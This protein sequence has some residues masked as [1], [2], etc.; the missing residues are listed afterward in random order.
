MSFS[1]RLPLFLEIPLIIR[2]TLLISSIVNMVSFLASAFLNA[3]IKI[4]P[5]PSA[6][7][8]YLETSEYI[9][10]HTVITHKRIKL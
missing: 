4:I 9:G 3:P 6:V 10:I 8:V 1:I 7:L 5:L 2:Q